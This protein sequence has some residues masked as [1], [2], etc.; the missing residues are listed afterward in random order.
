MSHFLR[1]TGGSLSTS[2]LN[3]CR[4]TGFGL[5]GFHSSNRGFPELS[6]FVAVFVNG[7]YVRTD[8]YVN[9]VLAA[10]DFYQLRWVRN[11]FL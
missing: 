8:M 11:L 1:F 5:L 9:M 2:F 7:M 4:G 3:R 6:L 10:F